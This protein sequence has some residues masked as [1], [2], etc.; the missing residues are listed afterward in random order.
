MENEDGYS[1]ERKQR[2]I[3]INNPDSYDN[4]LMVEHLKKIKNQE[5][6]F[7]PEYNHETDVR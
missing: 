4:E 7:I 5:E 6:T 2:L 1:V 3:E